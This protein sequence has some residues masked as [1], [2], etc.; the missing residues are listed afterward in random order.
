MARLRR[1]RCHP[2]SLSHGKFLPL[3]ADAHFS[4]PS[5]AYYSMTNPDPGIFYPGPS[6][7]RSVAPDG[8]GTAKAPFGAVSAACQIRGAMPPAG[9]VR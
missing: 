2:A 8:T 6:G 7:A 4:R 3:S 1:V 9:A 5:P